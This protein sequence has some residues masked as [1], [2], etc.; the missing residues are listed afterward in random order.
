MRSLTQNFRTFFVLLGSNHTQLENIDLVDVF[1]PFPKGRPN[2][3]GA[4]TDHW[5]C[6]LVWGQWSAFYELGV[7]VPRPASAERPRFF[8][9]FLVVFC[10]FRGGC[11]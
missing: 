2:Q 7:W 10:W 8:G 11:A 6:W 1:M 3:L 5:V 4:E 9:S